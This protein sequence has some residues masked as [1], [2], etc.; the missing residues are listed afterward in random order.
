MLDVNV[1]HSQ[2][3]GLRPKTAHVVTAKALGYDK[4]T[5]CMELYW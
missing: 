2:V 3:F 4:P 5:S 1:H